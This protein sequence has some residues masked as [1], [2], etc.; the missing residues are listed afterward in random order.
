MINKK[1]LIIIF[2][3]V[4]FVMFLISFFSWQ[5]NRFVDVN[6]LDLGLMRA[7]ELNDFDN[8]DDLISFSEYR[9]NKKERKSLYSKSLL[10]SLEIA[11]G[12][13]C[14]YCPNSLIFDSKIESEIKEINRIKA[15]NICNPFENQ[16][17]KK[18]D[19]K[20][21]DK[22]IN[23]MLCKMKTDKGTGTDKYSMFQLM[24]IIE[25]VLPLVN[26]VNI[27]NEDGSSP[28]SL[29]STLG[30][31]NLF[32]D[33]VKKGA[34]INY[35]DKNGANLLNLIV[36][37]SNQVD[38]RILNYLINKGVSPYKKDK[39][40]HSAYDYAE[41]KKTDNLKKLNELMD[42]VE[43]KHAITNDFD[44]YYYKNKDVWYE[45]IIKIFDVSKQHP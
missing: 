9:R 45:K 16:C 39:T 1:M 37:Y 28:L 32:M 15:C 19:C 35:I 43:K 5:Q 6:S 11:V 2:I 29:A 26:N 42:N 38:L 22:R 4:L 7:I 31:Y 10:Y 13:D 18:N 12:S 25:R 40:G 24:K 21:N 44:K 36:H 27:E 17:L 20:E 41:I 14:F 34:D 3:L 8:F 33:I 30:N 23:C